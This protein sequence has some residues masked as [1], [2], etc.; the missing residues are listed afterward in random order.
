MKNKLAPYF[1]NSG[2]LKHALATPITSILINTELAL[3]V[4]PRLIKPN[5]FHYLNQ[6]ML[7]ANYIK[8]VLKLADKSPSSYQSSFFIRPAL[9][10]VIILVEKPHPSVNF[11]IKTDC[12]HS[13][14]VNGPKL[15]F[16]EAM[17][18]LLNNAAESYLEKQTNQAVL[19]SLTKSG[20]KLTIQII[21]GGNGWDKNRDKPG[22]S[23]L[24]LKFVLNVIRKEFAG[25][26]QIIN[27]TRRRGTTAKVTFPL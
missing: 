12:Q 5:H 7:S 15:L 22:H 18:C 13:L 17:V 25:E 11:M 24:G 4:N 27:H 19:L 2:L 14:R 8:S 1:S 20:T 9:Q 21:D 26:L 23:G 3:A 6:I 10:E 16:Q